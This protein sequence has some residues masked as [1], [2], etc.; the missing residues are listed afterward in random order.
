M[1][2]EPSHRPTDVPP[3]ASGPVA[4]GKTVP[5]RRWRDTLLRRRWNGRSPTR[6]RPVDESR[7]GGRER[8]PQ[9][10]QVGVW[11]GVSAE[12]LPFSGPQATA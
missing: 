5:Q 1:I 6:V 3:R 9:F 7:L 10:L 11:A 12:R 8:R 2:R 4:T